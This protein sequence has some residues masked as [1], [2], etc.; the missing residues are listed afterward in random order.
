MEAAAGERAGRPGVRGRGS[1]KADRVQLTG[2]LH[3]EWPET[4]MHGMSPC[5]PSQPGDADAHGGGYGCSRS[6]AL[7]LP[8]SWAPAAVCAFGHRCRVAVIN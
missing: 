7:L 6:S 3:T 8:E 2:G 1:L 5:L 4:P